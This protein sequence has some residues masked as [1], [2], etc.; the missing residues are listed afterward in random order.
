MSP[1]KVEVHLPENGTE[2]TPHTF[3]NCGSGIVLEA[4]LTIPVLARAL[5]CGT[6]LMRAVAGQPMK[7]SGTTVL[8]PSI[9]RLA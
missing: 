8:A 9:S 5:H 6:G 1:R 3:F 7:V 4:T 2:Q